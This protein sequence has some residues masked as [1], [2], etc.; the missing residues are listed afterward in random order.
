VFTILK[1][2]DGKIIAGG[3]FTQYKG[4][5]NNRI[6]RINTDGNRDTTFDNSIGFDTEPYCI[7]QQSDG[8][9]I[10]G[11]FF[12]SYKNITSNNIVRINTDGNRDSSFVTGAGF[13]GNVVDLLIQ[14]D[15]KT[16]VGGGFTTY[17]NTGVN[18]ITRLN[19]DGTRDISFSTGSGFS[20]IVECLELQQDGKILVGGSFTQFNGSTANK[21][22]RLNS[23]G[24][25]DNT[26]NIGTGFNDN[27]TCLAVQPDQKIVV[28]GYFNNFNGTSYYKILRLNTNGSLDNTFISSLGLNYSPTSILVQNSGK[29]IVIGMFTSFNGTPANYI[30]RINSNGTIDNTFSSSSGFGD[31]TWTAPGI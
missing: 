14:P 21:L 10:I 12:N 2:T 3:A 16:L 28:G 18:Y 31:I 6:I 22:V 11:G 30:V 5:Q 17:N 27:V 25:I 24:T 8:K 13:N 20:D 26:F 9:L 19:S 1:Q 29:L 23:T 4:Q 15:G 7:V